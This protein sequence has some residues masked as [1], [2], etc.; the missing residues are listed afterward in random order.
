M[1]K[2]MAEQG[3]HYRVCYTTIIMSISG[4]QQLKDLLLQTIAQI[5]VIL[6]S[7]L[8]PRQELF[9]RL[10]ATD[11]DCFGNGAQA[12]MEAY[13]G[14]TTYASARTSS[15]AFLTNPNILKR[16]RE[17]MELYVNEEVV[18]R[19]LNFLILQDAEFNTKLG[20]IKH[21]NE[22]KQRITKKLDLT[23]DGGPLKV[24][25]V[26]FIGDDGNDTE[27]QS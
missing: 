15:S 20:A 5:D 4:L 22:L 7:Q 16:I 10:Y 2:P 8:T 14:S 21:Y 23:S 13:R 11:R 12:Y 19:E 1:A 24:A 26:E 18:D 17:L 9:C 25:L 6:G 3:S 27:N